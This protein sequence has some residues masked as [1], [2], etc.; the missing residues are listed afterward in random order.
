MAVLDLSQS[1]ATEY[2]E[3]ID[4]VAIKH[5]VHGK[6]GGAVLDT[7]G[8]TDKFIFEGHGVI[9]ETATGA[10][11]PLPVNGVIPEGHTI[12]GVVRSTTRT[13][14]PSTGIMTQ[15][16]INNN[17]VKYA[18]DATTLEALKTIGIYNQV[19]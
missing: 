1:E 18:F 2:S 7:T 16:T 3:G 13:S 5:Y 11:K 17:V 8:F 14:K 15:G 10:L 12:Y 9:Q 4:G 19:D 6:E